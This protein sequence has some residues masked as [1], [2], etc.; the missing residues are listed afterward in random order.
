MS[1][2]SF[3][4]RRLRRPLWWILECRHP[5]HA[6]STILHG[7]LIRGV[8]GEV[9]NLIPQIL[10]LRTSVPLELNC[11]RVTARRRQRPLCELGAQDYKICIR[12][13][14]AI[15]RLRQRRTS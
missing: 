15:G 12:N 2:R 8:I 9:E 5:S 14:L 10:I 3:L 4:S 11:W 7:A 1:R 6:F 13:G